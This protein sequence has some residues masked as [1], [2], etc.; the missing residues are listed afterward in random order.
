MGF[1]DACF[2]DSDDEI[3]QAAVADNW[4]FAALRR[5]GWKRIGPAKETARFANGG[6]DTPSGKVEFLSASARST[7]SRLRASA[8]STWPASARWFSERPARRSA[9]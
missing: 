6:F 4:D 2:G 5:E 9:R 1:A 7:T 8:S 3:A